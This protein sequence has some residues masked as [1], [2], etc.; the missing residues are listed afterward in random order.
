MARRDEPLRTISYIH[1]NTKNGIVDVCTDDLN[2]EQKSYVGAL[3]KKTYLNALFAGKATVDVDLPP[4]DEVFGELR[5]K[6][7]EGT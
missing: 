6:L 7:E 5:K 1:V 3:L 2:A 4:V